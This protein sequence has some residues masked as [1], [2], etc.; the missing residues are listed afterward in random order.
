MT[1]RPSFDWLAPV[2]RTLERLT[3]GGLLHW[4][5]TAH[6]DHLHERRKALIVGDGDGRF[7]A[8]LLRANP[9]VEV[10]SLDISPGM[11]AVAQQRIA[12]IPG[13]AARVRFVVADA[14]TDAL[15]ATGYDLVVTNF[16]LDC[17]RRPELAIVV[18]RLASAC[19]PNAMWVDG[20]FRVP[21][22]GWARPVARLAL[23]G[24][25]AFF[26]LATRLP[27]GA[28]IDPAPLIAAESFARASEVSRLGGFLSARLWT[29]TGPATAFGLPRAPI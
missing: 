20:D 24:M 6:L 4:C 5:R 7:L 28:L 17:F 18:H 26:R 3:F 12:T 27:A 21:R 29:R 19:A 11:I 2:Y 23:A 15:P 1:P 13:A 22:A 10:D 8:D 25:Y 16:V 9:N 14:R